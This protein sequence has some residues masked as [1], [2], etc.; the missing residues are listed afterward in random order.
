MPNYKSIKFILQELGNNP[1][2]RERFNSLAKPLGFYATAQGVY[3]LN[4]HLIRNWA[5]QKPTLL[6]HFIRTALSRV[7]GKAVLGALD[8]ET[9]MVEGVEIEEL[10]DENG[11]YPNEIPRYYTADHYIY[12]AFD[13]PLRNGEGWGKALE[14][15]DQYFVEEGDIVKLNV[16]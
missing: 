9:C 10:I 16:K 13:Q 1:E 8:R 11:P 3:G 2:D 4:G 5:K 14:A 12:Q 15:L 7:D 6:V